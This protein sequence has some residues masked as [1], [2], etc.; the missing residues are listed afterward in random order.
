MYTLRY[1]VI[2]M[3]MIPLGRIIG[4]IAA[5]IPK[6]NLLL[7][8]TEKAV[9]QHIPK[10]R[11]KE[12]LLPKGFSDLASGRELVMLSMMDIG[13]AI[14]EIKKRDK[15]FKLIGCATWDKIIEVEVKKT[16]LGL[17]AKL[18]IHTVKGELKYTLICGKGF[19]ISC[20]EAIDHVVNILKNTGVKLRVKR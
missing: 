4:I 3:R 18:V 8:I 9:C 1:G 13:K 20:D 19:G 6:I 12:I 5:R 7:I 2:V 10:T 17:G 15:G 16:F 14:E 11:V